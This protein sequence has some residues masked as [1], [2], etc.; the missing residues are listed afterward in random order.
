M[1]KFKAGV[2]ANPKGRPKGIPDK[3]T[4]LRTLIEPLAP[5]LI[6]V[7]YDMAV[8]GDVSALRLLLDKICPNVKPEMVAVPIAVNMAGTAS[9][10]C[11]SILIAIAA[12]N[13]AAD[14][15]SQLIRAI[16]DTVKVSEVT[17][18]FE[19]LEKL[20]NGGNA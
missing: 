15:G 3:R 17:D 2:A 8:A 19:R 12:G 6:E 16:A 5:A 9:E 11:Q 18:L 20:E 4:A 10:Q 1:A 13:I 14:T 7:A